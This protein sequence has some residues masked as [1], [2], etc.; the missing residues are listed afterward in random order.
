MERP[1]ARFFKISIIFKNGLWDPLCLRMLAHHSWSGLLFPG[2]GVLVYSKQH[3][4]LLPCLQICI[5]KPLISPPKEK[6]IQK[7]S[8]Q[9]QTNH[10]QRERER[11]SYA[12]AFAGPIV[13]CWCTISWGKKSMLKEKKATFLF[14]HTLDG[15]CCCNDDSKLHAPTERNER[16]SRS[17]EDREIRLRSSST[18]DKRLLCRLWKVDPCYLCP[19]Q[20]SP[21][22]LM[23]DGF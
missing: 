13:K 1:K 17:G 15:F 18:S 23:H 4:F 6:L 10:I 19:E 7:Q 5:L 21:T 3:H 12:A 20:C 9:C 14:K 2:K 22:F 16:L 8:L 11:E